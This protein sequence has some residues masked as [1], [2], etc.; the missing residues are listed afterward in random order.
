MALVACEGDNKEFLGAVSSASPEASR[1]GEFI[2]KKGGNAV[3]ASIAIS[4]ALAVTEP[5]MSGLGGGS[6]VLLSIKN[7][8]PIAI[9]GTTFSPGATVI[10]SL[11]TLSYHRRGTIPSTVKVL[12]YLYRS[13]G[14]GNVL[15][16]ELV[17]PAI[18]YAENGFEVGPFRAKVYQEYAEKLKESPHNT[19]LFFIDGKVPKVGERLKQPIL[20]KTLKRIAKFGADDF[21]KGKIAQAIADDMREN[22]GWISLEDLKRFSDPEELEPLTITFNGHEVYSQPPPCG[23]WTALMIMKLLEVKSQGNEHGIN[24]LIEALYLG[25]NDRRQHPVTDLI[26]Y[27]TQ[28]A[29]KLSDVYIQKLLKSAADSENSREII[30][31]GSG[32]TTHF[33]V[34]D[35]EGT[36]IAVTASINAYFGSQ[37]A[38]E[39]LGFLYN[40]Y[41]DDFTFGDHEHPFAI[42]PNAMA[43]SSMSPTIVQKNG[44]NLL[45]IGSPGS[46]R[47]ISSVAQ[48]AAQW[49]YNQDLG[50]LIKKPRV[51]VNRNR[52]YLE[53]KN[54]TLQVDGNLIQ[55]YD[56]KFRVPNESLIIHEQLNS[57]YGGIHAIAKEK[58]KWVGVADP[59]RDGHAI[60]VKN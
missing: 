36:A 59:R 41:M 44:E 20:A 1:A 56:L 4:F 13:Y 19:Y 32:E 49:T 18:E 12:D 25:Q 8:K 46:S 47:I 43:Y 39:R 3:D 42:R 23:G 38:S 28:V 10:E 55:K 54:D 51:H 31:E 5:A 33:S 29:E 52:I 35:S 11:D 24:D 14:S 9:N 50:H 30:K 57:Y 48:L 7:Q 26:N 2:L 45:V 21:Y 60:I 6:Q 16:E 34:V 17:Q 22:E 53:E 40:S 58:S 37:A 15:W 27:E